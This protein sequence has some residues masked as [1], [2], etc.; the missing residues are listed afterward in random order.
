MRDLFPHRARR[1]THAALLLGCGLVAVAAPWLVEWGWPRLLEPVE[2]WTVDV[3]FRLRPPLPVAAP[4]PEDGKSDAVAIIDYDDA[5]ARRYGLGRWPWDRR[6]HAQVVRWLHEWGARAVLMDLVF[7]HPVREVEDRALA[8]ATA[9]AGNVFYPVLIH[10]GREAAGNLGS[11]EIPPAHLFRPGSAPAGALPAADAWSLPLPL[12]AERAAGFGHIRRAVDSDGILRRLPVA[13]RTPNGF[14]PALSLAVALRHLGV[15]PATVRIEPG[16]ALRF[17]VRGEEVA[18]PVDR[19]GRMWINYAGLW[20]KRFLHFPYSWM[21][22]QAA[23]PEGR[24]EL[25]ALFKGRSVVVANLTTAA[26]DQGPVPFQQN[27]VFSEMHLHVLNMVLTRQ[28]LRDATPREA[29]LLTALP[30]LA[31]TAVALV[32]GPAV[33]LP[34]FLAAL[35]AMLLAAQRAFDGGVVVP[36]VPPAIALVAALVL[37]L[38]ARFLIVDRERWRFLSV[39]GSCLPPQTIREIRHNPHRIS[40]L[41]AGRRRELTVLFAD[42]RGFSTWCMTAQPLVVQQLLHEYLSAMSTVLR[43][44][45]GTL[46]KYMGDGIMA[47]FGDAEPE[48]DTDAEARV[49]RN[50]ANAVRAALGM[51]RQMATLNERWQGRAVPSGKPML[52]RIGV[53]TGEVTVGNLG[54][55]YLWDYT[56][57]G[58]EVN[59]AQR[60]ESAA[61][62]GGVLLSGRT[63]RLARAQGLLPEDLPRV[64]R[65]LKGL[66]EESDL[67]AVAPDMVS[68]LVERLPPAP[69]AADQGGAAGRRWWRRAAT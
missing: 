19:Q 44:A 6:V 14:I 69:A 52:L 4:S 57:V 66:G 13:Y 68:R 28:F 31:L 33:I 37:L 45:G 67:Y 30:A 39:L 10:L 36:A 56:V 47:F 38:A 63:Y 46:D 15:D 42:L 60:L 20:G 65:T 58:P 61:D 34:S 32:G 17:A 5:A 22:E 18:V 55:S 26:G 43:Q 12:L 62:P 2:L 16:V 23:E 3:R 35:G 21:L 8:Q 59:K 9:E 50:A 51:Q 7:E 25:A 54:T 1:W 29:L 24:A 11:P 40:D 27:F 64:T 41:L 48:D 53:N 49:A